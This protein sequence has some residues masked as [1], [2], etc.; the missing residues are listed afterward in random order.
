MNVNVIHVISIDLYSRYT[1]Y[2]DL[3]SVQ[4]M[5]ANG[6]MVGGRH[7]IYIDLCSVY[8]EC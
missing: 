3:C 6:P 5:N 8:N 2:I 4:T 7:C 1:C